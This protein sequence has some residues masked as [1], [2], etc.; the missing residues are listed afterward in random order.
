MQAAPSGAVRRAGGVP[1]GAARVL[2]LLV[3]SRGPMVVLKVLGVSLRGVVTMVSRAHTRGEEGG[4]ARSHAHK[5]C[6]DVHG[7]A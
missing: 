7:R 3:V 1:A 6:T 2:L 5:T 4:H